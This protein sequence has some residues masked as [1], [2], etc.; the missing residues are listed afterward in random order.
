LTVNEI[1]VLAAGELGVE[2]KVKNYLDGTNEEGKSLTEGLLRCFNL[3]ENEVALDYLPLYCEEDVESETGAIRFDELS[4]GAVRILRITDESGNKLPFKLFPEYVKTQAG[5]VTVAYTY[6]PVKKAIGDDSDF[7]V[8]ASP[9]LFAY[10]VASEYCLASGL[11]EEA[12]VWDKKYKD[13]LAAAYRAKP[14][15]IIRSRRWA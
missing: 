4:R 1:L 7:V 8:Q 5:S 13:A 10:G 11:F 9:R 12:A 2:E 3:V 6:A 14:S 15:R